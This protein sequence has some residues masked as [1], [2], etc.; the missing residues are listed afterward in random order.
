MEQFFFWLVQFA[1]GTLVGIVGYF[2]RGLKSS[3]DQNMIEIKKE[4]KERDS[5]LL[6]KLNQ[7]EKQVSDRLNKLER[8]VMEMKANM[9]LVY[10]FRDDYIRTMASFGNKLDKVLE[11]GVLHRRE[12]KT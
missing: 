5:Q 3:N 1:I 7:L 11:S 2:V 6:L 4:I 10:V 9:P 12:G 8:D